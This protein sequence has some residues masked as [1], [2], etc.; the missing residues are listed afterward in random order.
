MRYKE[1]VIGVDETVRE[2][3][4]G[5][6]LSLN[7]EGFS[8]TDDAL[9]AFIPANRWDAVLPERVRYRLEQLVGSGEILS[10]TLGI[11]DIEPQN[12]QE[13]WER[14]IEPIR[15]GR[16]IVVYPSWIP[17]EENEETIV[18]IIDPKMSFGTGH[19]ETTQMMMLLLERY[20]QPNRSVLD[21]GSGT[22]ILSILAARLG[23][24]RVIGIDNDID[25]F[26]NAKENCSA[27]GVEPSVTM[28]H[29]DLSSVQ[30]LAGM[31]FDI[32]MANI[33][34]K[35]IMSILDSL[36]RLRRASG[37]LLLSGLLREDFQAI[38]QAIAGHGMRIIE[39]VERTS[40]TMDTWIAITAGT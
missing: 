1:L 18:I 33:E 9:H 29:G 35:T 22:G 24:S 14:T 8:E 5:H 11:A 38:E 23:A 39:T 20:M 28:Y 10:Y 13:Q 7:F 16:R 36:Q 40:S 25:A 15:I 19:H 2:N 12:W 37:L 34:R 4:V 3:L 26:D 21:V 6:L 27:N 31:Q 32:I 30:E 17:V